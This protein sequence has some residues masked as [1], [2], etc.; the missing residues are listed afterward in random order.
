MEPELRQ[1]DLEVGEDVEVI[2]R[3]VRDGGGAVHPVDHPATP[4]GQ[5]AEHRDAPR[6]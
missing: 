2:H 4:A 6:G 1:H 3:L 5:R